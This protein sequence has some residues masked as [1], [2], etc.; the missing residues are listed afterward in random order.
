MRKDAKNATA[1]ATPNAKKV[2]IYTRT[3][4]Q[5]ETSLYGGKRVA[6]HNLQV[7]SYGTVDELNSCLG[8]V[9]AHLNEDDFLKQFLIKLQFDLLTIGSHL[10]GSR[11]SLDTLDKR[12]SEIEKMIDK[13]DE[14]LPSLK[15]FILP[16]GSK[17]SSF[18]HLARSICRRTEREIIK[19]SKKVTID[20]RIIMYLNRLSDF[21]FVL[22]RYCNYKSQVKDIIWSSKD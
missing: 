18:T 5:G 12:I 22:A 1:V 17:E 3:G 10:A 4:D 20:R 9:I 15:N 19:L 2:K 8:I 13:M 21:L 11:K 14:K 16:G 7:A 6:K